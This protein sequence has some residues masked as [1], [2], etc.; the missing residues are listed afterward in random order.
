MNIREVAL[1]YIEHREKTVLEMQN[2]LLDKG[3]KMEEIKDTIEYLL[4]SKYLDDLRYCE[5]YVRYALGKRRGMKRIKK[6]LTLAGINEFD[7]M[8]GIAAYEDSEAVDC[9]ILQ[10]E[11]AL[12]EADKIVGTKKIDDKLIA[13][14]G[15]RL[16]SLGYDSDIIYE[17][18]GRY[19]R[20][21]Y[22]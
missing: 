13:K 22:E 5:E 21:Q 6:E 4:E 2:H 18:V 11:A 7:L 12:I 3:F 1:K 9:D 19:M 10:K 20:N 16:T 15:R 14:V 8:D 17:I